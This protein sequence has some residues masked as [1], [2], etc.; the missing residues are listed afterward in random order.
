MNS[1]ILLGLFVF[2][3]A[4][5]S[6]TS[7]YRSE[8]DPHFWDAVWGGG[9]YSEVF[10]RYT[11]EKRTQSEFDLTL[12]A[13]VTYWGD[14][15]RHSYVNEFSDRYRLDP[16]ESKAL[17]Y[18]QLAEGESYIVFIMSAAT[19]YPQWNDFHGKSSIWRV[20]LETP[21]GSTRASPK[22]VEKVSFKNERAMYFY[23]TM[24]RFKETY[25]VYFD[26][27]DFNQSG[28][29]IFY[30]TGPRGTLSYDFQIGQPG[31]RKLSSL[32]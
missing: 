12:M 13:E 7:N 26:K 29:A 3:S 21:N 8:S 4:C 31:L 6:K 10:Y 2:C 28:E 22:K 18:E 24:G 9:N 5:S 16:E 23:P 11:K 27:K 30:I 25:K 17:A 19:R 32:E 20:T 1:Y 14:E 15:L